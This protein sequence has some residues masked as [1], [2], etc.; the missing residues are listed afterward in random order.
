MVPETFVGKLI[1]GLCCICGVLV[2]ALPIPIIV[3]NFA[4]F[5]KEQTRK[6]KALKRNR[7]LMEA[8]LSGS[9]LSV[10]EAPDAEKGDLNEDLLSG[11][12][13]KVSSK[14]SSIQ[15]N[16]KNASEKKSSTPPPSP[17][18]Y[19]P[20]ITD[21]GNNSIK[22]TALNVALIDKYKK[23]YDCSNVPETIS[24]KENSN[25]H[26]KLSVSLPSVCN[27]KLASQDKDVNHDKEA[28]KKGI[29]NSSLINKNTINK[30]KKLQKQQKLEEGSNRIMKLIKKT[31][32][33]NSN[34]KCS[35]LNEVGLIFLFLT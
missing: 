1:G 24:L 30:L 23:Y 2:I 9:F 26:K 8:R 21:S 13:K 6:E 32:S 15:I 4:D 14:K 22:Q 20:V 25:H 16:L 3:N 28:P 5:Y 11:K 7:E 35:S 17:R 18:R 27:S 34:N 12:N 31:S 19:S 29:K 33:F 10:G